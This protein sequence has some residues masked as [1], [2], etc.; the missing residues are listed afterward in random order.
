MFSCS[1]HLLA[2]FGSPLGLLGFPCS[3][4]RF[5]LVQLGHKLLRWLSSTTTIVSKWDSKSPITTQI[6]YL[7]QVPCFQ[8]NFSCQIWYERPSKATK[9]ISSRTKPRSWISPPNQSLKTS[10]WS[11]TPTGGRPQNHDCQSPPQMHAH[12]YRHDL[13]SPTYMHLSTYLWMCIHTIL[14]C[15]SIYMHIYMQLERIWDTRKHTRLHASSACAHT[16]NT[17]GHADK[18]PSCKQTYMEWHRTMLDAGTCPTSSETDISLGS[19]PTIRN[20]SYMDWPVVS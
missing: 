11:P 10:A 15:S 3:P 4:N 12:K 5:W 8:L 14:A 1:C 19:L 18:C 13:T 7:F 16:L 2:S 17:H 9:H 20:T 6:C